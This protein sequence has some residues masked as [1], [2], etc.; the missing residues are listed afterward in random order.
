M[1]NI[2]SFNSTGKELL[3]QPEKSTQHVLSCL[4]NKSVIIKQVFKVQ[5]T[6]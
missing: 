3:S 2:Q 6:V 5:Q 4:R 1:A